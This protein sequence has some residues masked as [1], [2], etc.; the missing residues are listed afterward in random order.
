MAEM[1][2]RLAKNP[3][4]KAAELKWSSMFTATRSG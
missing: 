4:Q 2:I 1:A 3:R